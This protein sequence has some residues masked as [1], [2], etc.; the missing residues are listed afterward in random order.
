MDV[1]LVSMC[2]GQGNM[3]E[4]NSRPARVEG[5]EVENSYCLLKAVLL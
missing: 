3:S 1:G 2:F 4:S 5:G